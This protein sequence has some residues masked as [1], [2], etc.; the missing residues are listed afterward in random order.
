MVGFVSIDCGISSG[1]P[2]TDERTNIT[3]SSDDGYISTG[4]NHNISPDSAKFV[5]GRQALNLRSFPAGG[6]NCYTIDSVMQG[7]KYNVRAT[8]MHGNY[9]ESADKQQGV[10][11]LFDLYIGVNFWTTV[12]ITN[13]SIPYDCDVIH[14][15]TVNT[16]SVCLVHINQGTPF[17]SSLE[18]RP[19]KNSLYPAAMMNQSLSLFT[20]H[21]LGAEQVIR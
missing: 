3:Y 18:V 13:T 9:D 14:V 6:R 1:Y 11:V 8:F 7:N 5:V 20:R 10:Y 2:Y 17:I 15:A 12:N 21:N 4:E 19:L 16:I